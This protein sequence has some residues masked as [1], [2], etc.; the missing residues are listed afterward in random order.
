MKIRQLITLFHVSVHF[1]EKADTFELF[2]KN[3]FIADIRLDSETS[4]RRLDFMDIAK[5]QKRKIKLSIKLLI[6][7]TIYYQ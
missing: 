3:S 1:T 6:R 5:K 7:P 4:L 2:C